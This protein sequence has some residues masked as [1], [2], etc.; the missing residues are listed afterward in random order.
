MTDMGYVEIMKRIESHTI[1]SD[2]MPREMTVQELSSWL[3]G[4]AAGVEACK[5]IVSEMSRSQMD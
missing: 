1:S 3:N 2:D 4:Y 5:E